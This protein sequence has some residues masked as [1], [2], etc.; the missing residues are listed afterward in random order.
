MIP[1]ESLHPP[2][3]VGI[4]A[5]ELARYHAFTAAWA[6]LYVPINTRPM[7]V[8][9]YDT[10]YNSNDIIRAALTQC[11]TCLKTECSCQPRL[12]AQWVQ[13]FDDDHTFAPDLLIR[14][15]D[16]QVDVLMPLYTQRQPPFY[17]CLYKH[18]HENGSC[19][20]FRWEDLEG[21]SGLLPIASAG[22]GGILIRRHVFEKLADPWFERQGNIGEDHLFFRKCHEAGFGVYAD[23]DRPM[24]HL[25]TVETRP[26]QQDG[27]WCGAVDLKRGVTVEL[28]SDTYNGT[29]HTHAVKET[30]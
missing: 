25:T 15:L 3:I 9:S 7:L 1:I 24:G 2:G 29:S 17:P 23:L 6:S 26:H 13:I 12:E 28:W 16:R 10:A 14:M 8:A 18:Q 21:L 20:I 19:D 4:S 11:L 27:K 22:K 5:A 30:A